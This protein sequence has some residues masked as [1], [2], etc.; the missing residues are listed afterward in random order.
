MMRSPEIALALALSCAAPA[1][2]AE[3]SGEL[4]ALVREDCGSCHGM[5][6]KGGPGG[7][8]APAA[9]AAKDAPALAALILDGVPGT[10]MPPW[11]GLLTEADARWIAEKLKQGFPQ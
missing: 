11:R 3:R 5:T 6:L 1:L 9:V 7:P 4:T 10:P 8:L 2:A